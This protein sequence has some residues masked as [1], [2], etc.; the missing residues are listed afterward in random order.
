MLQRPGTR[1]NTAVR[2]Q[3]DTLAR[4][5]RNLG[6]HVQGVSYR[7]RGGRPDPDT[8]VADRKKLLRTIGSKL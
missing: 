4:H 7:L 1:V 3:L 6:A 5:L 2:H 8:D